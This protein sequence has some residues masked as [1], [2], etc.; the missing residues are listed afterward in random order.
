MLE[1]IR[2]SKYIKHKTGIYPASKNSEIILF[3]FK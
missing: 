2:I 3:R 1:K